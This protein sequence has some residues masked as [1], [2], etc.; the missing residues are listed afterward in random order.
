MV[1]IKQQWL[2]RSIGRAALVL[3]DK[4]NIIHTACFS[5]E[6]VGT[7]AND[8]L[9]T[10]LVTTI[11]QS[12]KT[13][14][15]V[16]AHIGSI[17]SEVSHINSSIK[18]VAIEAIPEKV[19]HLRRKFPTVELHD[20]AV[21]DSPGEVPFFINLRH[22]GYSSLKKP[23]SEHEGAISEIRVP[24]KRLDEIVSSCGVDVIKID[25]EGVELSVL[26]GSTKI[27]NGSRPTILFESGPQL[28]DDLRDT[29]EALYDFL[30]LNDYVVVIPNRVA[31]DDFGLS[32]EEFLKSHLYPRQTTNYFAIPQERRIEIRNRARTILKIPT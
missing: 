18:I 14:V 24:I 16:G 28:D 8:Q 2:G 11:C 26:R 31:H 3:R 12:H 30:T 22:S 25:V 7:V 23:I 32:K 6:I 21:G 19:V 20:C 29:K 5:P 17:I 4:F 1:L 9:A 13:F 27:L 15:D 10:K